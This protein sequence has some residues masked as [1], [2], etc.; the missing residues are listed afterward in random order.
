MPVTSSNRRTLLNERMDDN[1]V[2]PIRKSCRYAMK[3]AGTFNET[4]KTWRGFDVTERRS[5]QTSRGRRHVKL[6]Q[7]ILDVISYHESLSV[8]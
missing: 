2:T 5:T 8:S 3:V 7:L 6:I 4:K 1:E